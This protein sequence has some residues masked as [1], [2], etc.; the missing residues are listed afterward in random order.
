VKSGRK[1]ANTA[2]DP[3]VKKFVSE[4]VESWERL[5]RQ[6]EELSRKREKDDCEGRE[7]GG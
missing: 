4:A 1:R 6:A 2:A 5:A 7:R 3:K